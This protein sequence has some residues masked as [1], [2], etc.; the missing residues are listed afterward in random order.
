[1]KTNLLTTT[2]LLLG[3]ALFA[4]HARADHRLWREL[5]DA[6]FDALTHARDVRW[7]IHDHFTQSRDYDELL[8]DAIALTRALRNVQDAVDEERDPRAIRRLVD[9]VHSVIVH[10]EEHA[11]DSEY[12]R[13]VPGSLYLGRSGYGYRPV[14]RH[15]GYVHVQALIRHLRLVDDAVHVL[16][17]QLDLMAGGRHQH[18]TPGLPGN[19]SPRPY[20]DGPSV[21]APHSAA[22]SASH[23]RVRTRPGDGW[24]QIV[25][26]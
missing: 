23:P 2:S 24:L 7:E 9:N 15:A 10:L 4:G 3:L 17:E 12:F 14:S 26:D 16:E 13:T 25:L 6:A 18:G 22:T 19:P 21:P 1:M 5:D 8:E 11:R 20:Y